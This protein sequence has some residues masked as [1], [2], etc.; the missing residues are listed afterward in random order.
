LKIARGGVLG[1]CRVPVAGYYSRGISKASADTRLQ[2]LDK[3]NNQGFH[4]NTAFKVNQYLSP[5]IYELDI[6][7]NLIY[8]V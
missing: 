1:A 4:I 2:C 6:D 7:Y 5:Q 3:I 8:T